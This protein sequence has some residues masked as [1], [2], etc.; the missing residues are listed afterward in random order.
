MT[1]YNIGVK[2]KDL[3]RKIHNASGV[4][5]FADESIL[6][7]PYCRWGLRENDVRK[8]KR[9]LLGAH[10]RAFCVVEVGERYRQKIWPSK[11]EARFGEA[12]D[13]L[14]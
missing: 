9:T 13:L 6:G 10:P 14:G 8:M 12:L 5:L 1:T 4:V 3:K 2:T 11:S 7:Y